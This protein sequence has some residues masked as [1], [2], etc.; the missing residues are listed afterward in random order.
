MPALSP[1]S[2]EASLSRVRAGLEQRSLSVGGRIGE[3]LAAFITRPG[4]MLRARFCLHLG[5]SLGVPPE[6]AESAG[7]VAELVHNASLLHDDCI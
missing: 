7:R 5:A 3:Q 6:R 1:A 2:I 4:K